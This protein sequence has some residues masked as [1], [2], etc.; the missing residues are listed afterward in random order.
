MKTALRLLLVA[1]ALHLALSAVFRAPMAQRDTLQ[2]KL[3]R[4]KRS[5]EFRVATRVFSARFARGGAHRLDVA[6]TP[7]YDYANAEYHLRIGVGTPPQVFEVIP[8]TGSSQVWVV[9]A[10]CDPNAAY[11]DCP[12]YCGESPATCATFCADFCCGNSTAARPKARGDPCANKPLFDRSASATYE[13]TGATFNGSSQLGD[14]SGVLGRD[15][16]AFGDLTI[17]AVTF[18]QADRLS[19]SFTNAPWAG[20]LGLGFGRSGFDSQPSVVQRAIDAGLLDAPLFTVWL[21][22]RA[23]RPVDEPAGAFTLGA[24]DDAHCSAATTFVP[25]ASDSIFAITAAGFGTNG[26][27]TDTSLKVSFPPCFRLYAVD[28]GL[29]FTWSVWVN[30]GDELR[31]DQ[32][33]LTLPGPDGECLLNFV[34]FHDLALGIELVL[35]TPFLRQF[36]SVYDVGNQQ[37]GFSK[38]L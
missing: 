14:V 5:H 26:A 28:C 3:L 15:S 9:D 37:I 34:H 20:I 18:G 16:F 23:G 13:A 7:F 19:V 31:V 21:E 10:T 36:C 38:P 29:Q 22:S 11:N 12:I 30:D 24:L 35:G 25:L 6:G 8:E 17:P 33:T 2:A 27:K 4:E 1:A 32:S